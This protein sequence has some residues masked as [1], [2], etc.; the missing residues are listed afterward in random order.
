MTGVAAN[1]PQSIALTGTGASPGS[2]GAPDFNLT[3]S[4]QSVSA[5]SAGG[6]VTFQVSA[7]PLNGFNQTLNLTCTAPTGV[8][9]AAS[10]TSLKMDGTSVPTATVTLTIAGSG[11][12]INPRTAQLSLG[13]SPIL[14]SI[15]PLGILGMVAAGR[16]RRATL[17]L[18]L[19]LIGTVLFSVNCGSGGSTTSMAPGTYQ[20]TITGAATGTSAV[21]HSTTVTLTV[22]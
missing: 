18:L 1:S 3:S 10:P 7:T 15:F 5:S 19:I 20:V 8:T 12:G 11:G 2:S 17:V 22:N 4:Q 9:C 6:N 16:K 21:S 13:R 14:A